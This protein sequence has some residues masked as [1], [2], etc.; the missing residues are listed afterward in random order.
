M[1]RRDRT[2]AGATLDRMARQR[3]AGRATGVNEHRDQARRASANARKQEQP[4]KESVMLRKDHEEGS[5][6][7]ARGAV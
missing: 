1:M 7:W 3:S 5:E 6:S 2:M 4:D